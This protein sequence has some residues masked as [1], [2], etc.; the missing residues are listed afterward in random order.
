[1]KYKWR[2]LIFAIVAVAILFLVN[3]DVNAQCSMCRAALTGTNNA[4]FLRNFN[5]GVLVL[6]LPP[7]SIFC[8]IF[9]V[10]K[11]HSRDEGKN[12]LETHEP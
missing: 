7:V 8:S 1:M 12:E 9:I 6:L 10:L 3:S 4:R 5:I 2:L 11:R